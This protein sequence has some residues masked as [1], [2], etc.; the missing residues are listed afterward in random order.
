M[1]KAPAGGTGR[2]AH[3]GASLFRLRL[4]NITYLTDTEA[5]ALLATGTSFLYCRINVNSTRCILRRFIST[6]LGSWRVNSHEWNP[7]Q[8]PNPYL[9][10]NEEAL[11][12]TCISYTFLLSRWLHCIVKLH[13]FACLSRIWVSKT[14]VGH[15]AFNSRGEYSRTEEEN[16]IGATKNPP[17]ELQVLKAHSELRRLS[18]W[19]SF[20]ITLVLF[21]LRVT[22]IRNNQ[23]SN[24]VQFQ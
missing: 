23:N 9:S 24:T 2:M 21:A 7:W 13:S 22:H 12:L 15:L 17:T 18:F 10:S 3:I 20:C 11:T 14:N 4:W 5:P 16:N 19:R 8:H 1:R 6:V